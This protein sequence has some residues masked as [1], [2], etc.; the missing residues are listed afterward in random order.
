MD[1][2]VIKRTNQMA[3]D[4]IWHRIDDARREGAF[5]GFYLVDGYECPPFVMFSANDTGVY[6]DASYEPM[7]MK[8]WCRLCC[9]ATG[10]FDIGSHGGLY[11]LAAASIRPEL[12]IQAFEPNPYAFARLRLHKAI[13][14]CWN[15]VENRMALSDANGIGRLSWVKRSGL[16]ISAGGSLIAR[17][18]NG[19]YETATTEVCRLDSLETSAKI[20]KRGLIKIDVEG[21]EAAAFS[22]MPSVLAMRP[23]III[24]T[25]NQARC[26]QINVQ[27]LALGYRVYSINEETLTLT[28]QESLR[29]ADKTSRSF[30]QLLTVRPE[31]EITAI[32]E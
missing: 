7:A 29:P 25:F 20:G 26:E 16:P 19:R 18:D 24:E 28:M 3:I 32:L 8:V 11:S 14:G 27:L 21:A 9:V 22:G 30:N 6:A 2:D 1:I 4:H 12:Q 10:I 15:I 31:A 23:D 13:N 17:K 5:Y